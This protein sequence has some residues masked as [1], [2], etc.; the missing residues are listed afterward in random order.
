[1]GDRKTMGEVVDESIQFKTYQETLRAKNMNSCNALLSRL[2]RFHGEAFVKVAPVVVIEAPPPE[3]EPEL[4]PPPVDPKWIRAIE[5]IPDRGGPS[6]K[7]IKLC[8]A[9]HFK[10]SPRDLES[11]RRFAKIVVPR[12]I[13]FY[14]ARKL[15]TKSFPDIGRRFGGKDH[16]TILHACK[17]VERRMEKDPKLAETVRCLEEQLQ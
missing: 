15:T 16:T 14:L 8:V 10:L 2:T 7:E 5:E 3:P 6:V 4:P 17:V 11:P 13:A 1:M 12:Q 9:H